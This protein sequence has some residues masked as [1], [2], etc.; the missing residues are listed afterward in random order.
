MSEQQS[1]VFAIQKIYL[2]DASLEIPNAPHIF[3]ENGNPEIEV[4]VHTQAAALGQ[5]LFEAVLTVTVTAKI[6]DKTVFLIEAAQA[7]I[8]QIR[9]VPEQNLGPVL[10]IT[11]PDV[12]L[13]YVRE[14]VSGMVLRA[15]F[16]PV[17]LQHMSF[18][19]MYQQRQQQP[20]QPQQ[21]GGASAAH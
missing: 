11:C 15:G 12:L 1:P 3:L 18:E 13:P 5:D 14:V 20:Q 21:S 6:Q 4:S 2:K 17:I 10:G 7:G 9:N 8:F 19:A 16:P